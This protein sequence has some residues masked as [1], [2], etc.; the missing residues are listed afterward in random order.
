MNVAIKVVD[1]LLI[2]AHGSFDPTGD[3]WRT[4]LDTIEKHGITRTQHLIY[5]DGGAPTIAQ[6]RE[7]TAVLAGRVVPT[8][9]VFDSLR[10]RASLAALSLFNSSIKSFPPCGLADALRFLEVPVSR[11]DLITRELQALRHA[12]AEDYDR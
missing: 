7:L 2:I 3:E 6:Y 5:T 8:A 11:F 12:V 10:V 1:R 9:V 4:C